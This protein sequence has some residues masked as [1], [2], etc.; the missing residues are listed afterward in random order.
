MSRKGSS[1]TSFLVRTFGFVLLCAGM[2]VW[3]LAFG[4][5]YGTSANFGIVLGFILVIVGV[6]LMVLA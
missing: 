5:D 2:F 3:V 1:Y 6:L 4:A